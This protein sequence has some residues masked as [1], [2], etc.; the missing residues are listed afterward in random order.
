[1]NDKIQTGFEKSVE[2]IDEYLTE[3]GRPEM[4]G[5]VRE[6]HAKIQVLM[7]Q[8]EDLPEQDRQVIER[9]EPEP[10]WS[11]DNFYDF[12][13]AMY[14]GRKCDLEIRHLEWSEGEWENCRNFSETV[15]VNNDSVLKSQEWQLRKPQSAEDVLRS[16]IQ[17]SQTTART[18]QLMD[19]IKEAK[20][21]IS[22][23]KEAK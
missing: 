22:F 2:I 8:L 19:A 11:P 1:M 13:E 7:W 6:M 10:E 12:F 15:F 3:S 5:V 23:E 14:L 18:S 4:A 9:P 20:I 17:A 16:I 21:K